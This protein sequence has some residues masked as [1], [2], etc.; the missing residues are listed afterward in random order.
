M[1][2]AI[3]KAF[4]V[5]VVSAVSL[6]CMAPSIAINVIHQLSHASAAMPVV[7]WVYAS[8]SVLSVLLAGGAPVAGRHLLAR[9]QWFP[10]SATVV[11][12]V[13]C[14]GYNLQ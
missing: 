3:L 10:L 14:A 4:L 8:G 11:L 2:R 6:V 5:I 7:G 9:R 12:F 13:W 1:S